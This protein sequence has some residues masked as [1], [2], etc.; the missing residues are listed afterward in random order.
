[1]GLDDGMGLD[2]GSQGRTQL[3]SKCMVDQRVVQK[4]DSFKGLGQ[5]AI[6]PHLCVDERDPSKQK[7]ASSVV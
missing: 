5:V 3:I 1:M 6:T 7:P 4:E 2:F